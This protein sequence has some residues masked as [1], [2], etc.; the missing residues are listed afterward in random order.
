MMPGK[1]VSWELKKKVNK[2]FELV[3]LRERVVNSAFCQTDCINNG[4]VLTLPSKYYFE[5]RGSIYEIVDAVYLRFQG[6]Y[7]W[8]KGYI[9]LCKIVIFACEGSRHP[10]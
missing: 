1:S 2:Y 9:L 5:G 7:A 8:V 6:V 3:R 10:Y 4:V